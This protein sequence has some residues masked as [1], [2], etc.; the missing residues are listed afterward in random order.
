MAALSDKDGGV[1]FAPRHVIFDLDGTLLDSSEGIVN[2][3]RATLDELGMGA[4]EDQL[5]HLIG[6]PLW[7]SFRVLGVE[8]PF[9]DE[10]VALY[11]RHYAAFGVF[12]ATVYAGIHEVLQEMHATG[13]ALGVATAKRVDFATQML[14]A[15][16]LAEYFDIIAGAS[17]DLVV[18]EKYDIIDEALRHWG[19]KG[20]SAIW[21]IGDRRYDVEAAKRHGLTTIGVTWGFGSDTELLECGADAL[22]RVPR[23]LLGPA[24]RDEG[25]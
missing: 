20:S 12:E 23:D 24:W 13:I 4:D 3:F 1:H 16:H 25:E 9:V 15:H 10:A 8:A 21:M 7:H 11:R 2:S 17:V 19:E 18:S 5:R 14:G 22:A 6:P